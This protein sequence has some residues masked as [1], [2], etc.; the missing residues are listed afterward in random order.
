MTSPPGRSWC[1]N[2]LPSGEV[3][4][5]DSTGNVMDGQG[6]LAHFAMY[7]SNLQNQ[8]QGLNA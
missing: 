7:R 3:Q 6:L 5:L 1:F 4:F 8:L 2:T